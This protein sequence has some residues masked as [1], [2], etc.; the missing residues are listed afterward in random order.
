MD[1]DAYEHE[2][3]RDRKRRSAASGMPSEPW[4]TYR[5]QVLAALYPRIRSHFLSE[6]QPGPIVIPGVIAFRISVE[7]STVR[8]VLSHLVAEG[9]VRG[10]VDLPKYEEDGSPIRY[11]VSGDGLTTDRV[12]WDGKRWVTALDPFGSWR[13]VRGKDGRI[14]RN[15][16]KKLVQRALRKAERARKPFDFDGRGFEVLRDGAPYRRYGEVHGL[17]REPERPDPPPP[18]PRETCKRCGTPVE[19]R[20]RHG[21]RRRDHGLRKCN[22]AL[23]RRIME[24]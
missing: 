11:S 17:F 1:W 4:R 10:P 2:D 23:V 19:F 16:P 3:P 18:E 20:T 24:E 8:Q 21:K 9:F 13:T 5:P 12:E 14:W 6:R 7:V 22:S 15:P